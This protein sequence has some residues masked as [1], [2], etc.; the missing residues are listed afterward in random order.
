MALFPRPCGWPHLSLLM[1]A[2]PIGR[3]P[4][5]DREEDPTSPSPPDLP[6]H[7]NSGR[8]AIPG[9]KEKTREEEA[10]KNTQKQ[11]N[12]K[13]LPHHLFNMLINISDTH[14]ACRAGEAGERRKRRRQGHACCM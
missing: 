6:A 9:T 14:A 8:V 13:D 2:Y 4:G 12:W 11:K 7:L 3:P 1:P 10:V 5:R